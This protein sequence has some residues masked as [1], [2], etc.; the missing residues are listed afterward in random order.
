MEKNNLINKDIRADLSTIALNFLD[1][2]NKIDV[3]DVMDILYE[4]NKITQQT[5]DEL[6]KTLF[7]INNNISKEIK[8]NT[9]NIDYDS[10]NIGVYDVF[11]KITNSIINNINKVD[12]EQL[13]NSLKPKQ[14]DILHVI[15]KNDGISSQ[16]IKKI[17]N[18]KSQYLYN[19]TNDDRF[20]KI[21][22]VYKNEKSK[23]VFYSLN[24][25][26]RETLKKRYEN[27]EKNSIPSQF[28]VFKYELNKD[29]EIMEENYGY[30]KTNKEFSINRK[31]E[32]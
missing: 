7:N 19:L 21:V 8:R 27:K 4:V 15:Y 24:L 5:C 9:F 10:Y 26:S 31:F 16:Q 32:C 3:K 22:N 18:I 29:N 11:K 28:Y 30:W 14:L 2:E 17:L 12:Y 6:R 25:K 13:I 1:S 23:N 20:L